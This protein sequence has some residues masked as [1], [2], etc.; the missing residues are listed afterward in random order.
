MNNSYLMHHGIKGQKWGVRRFQNEDGTLTPLGKK[1]YAR[2]ELAYRDLKKQVRAKRSEIHGA[3]NRWMVNTPIG[4]NSKKYLDD[5][6]EKRNK[7]LNSDAWKAWEREWDRF[8]KSSERAIENGTMTFE[9]YDAKNKEL[10]SRRPKK[11]FRDPWDGGISY[12]VSGRKYADGYLRGAGKDLTMAYLKD[13][14][15]DDSSAKFL[16]ER[17][18]KA[19]RSLGMV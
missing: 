19:N 14:N 8:E 18:I 6:R 16:V 10:W 2:G 17:M 12:G 7:Y 3:S 5:A 9:E 15:Y 13:L 4:P 1:R 11:G